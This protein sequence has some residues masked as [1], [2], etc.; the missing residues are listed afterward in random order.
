MRK[1]PAVAKPPAVVPKPW[2]QHPCDTGDSWEAFKKYRDLRPPRRQRA[3]LGY[4][5]SRVNEWFNDNNWPQ[6]VS[7]YDAH[8]ERVAQTEREQ[9][10]KQK[11]QEI[12]ADHMAILQTAR[13]LVQSE[14]DKLMD[15][16]KM[17]EAH[18]LLKPADVAKFMEL[19]IR[20]DRLIRGETTDNETR[21]DL[22]MLS[23]D[24]LRAVREIRKKVDHAAATS[25]A[26]NPRQ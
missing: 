24:D 4:A 11:T 26:K 17:S 7:A 3:V 12:T 10:V 8:M 18:G 20:F 6:R 23:V 15:A 21:V 25:H 19:S 16:S 1:K 5:T 14:L 9:F 13:F 22:S 2:E